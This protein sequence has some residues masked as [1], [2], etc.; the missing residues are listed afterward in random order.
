VDL[1]QLQ[2]DPAA[3]RRALLIDRDGKPTLFAMI[4]DDW[5]DWDFR[6]LD[7]GWKR[8]AGQGG[9][10]TLRAYLERPRGHSKTADLA[11][12]STWAL[13]AS[14]RRLMG[15]AAAADTD[16]AK[17]LRDAID[18]LTR[19]NPW[20]KSI[21][22]VDKLKIT[23]S[24]TGSTLEIL[25]SDA[26]TSYGLTPDFVICDELCHWRNRDL[27]DSLISSAAK[28]AVCMVVVISNAGFGESWQ[29]EVR[30]S[31]RQDEDRWY[32]SRLDGPVASWITRERL[33]EQRRL[34]PA[35]AYNRLWLNEWS[36]GSGDALDPEDIDRAV[37]LPGPS[38]AEPG[39]VYLAGLDLGLKKD[40][41]AFVTVGCHWGWTEEIAKPERQLVG[42]AK[43]LFELGL[44]DDEGPCRDEEPEPIRHEG[45]G[46]LLVARVD[47]WKPKRGKL[48]IEPI[49]KAILE[50]HRRYNLAAVGYDPWQSE[51]LAERLRKAGVPM[52][53]VTFVPQNLQGMAQATLEAFNERRVDL[54]DHP[55]LLA[56][57]RALRVVEKGYG[58]R[59]E[60]PRGPS[61]HGDC[62]TAMS[63]GMHIAKTHSFTSSPVNGIL[64][65]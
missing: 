44:L 22:Q 31:V 52:Q 29:W 26:P 6:V 50:I 40:A 59:L 61:G 21:L 64:V 16:Q 39:Y 47:V 20:L 5:Q 3:F 53:A 36:S 23:N 49:E 32:F 41:S 43:A 42:A 56:D 65:Y 34:L 4:M 58:I 15:Y 33:E 11:V 28:R 46:R 30:E 7:D 18:G 51:Y 55:Q 35:I 57:L 12:M 8:V 27:W 13:F 63:I 2:R 60:S 19:L 62:A 1:K 24:R 9:D 38:P 14:R 17:L 45:T 54:Y 37:V 48:D 25:T 10:G